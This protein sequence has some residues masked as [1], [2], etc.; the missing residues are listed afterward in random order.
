MLRIFRSITLR[1]DV[2]G[3]SL[4][5]LRWL[6][7]LVSD[8]RSFP[9]H[10]SL[11]AC[12]QAFVLKPQRRFSAA[13]QV[14]VCLVNEDLY[15]VFP[16]CSYFDSLTHLFA[17]IA[18]IFL[19]TRGLIL[20]GLITSLPFL[21]LLSLICL[22]THREILHLTFLSR[23][24]IWVLAPASLQVWHGFAQGSYPA[25]PGTLTSDRD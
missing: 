24:T 1:F 14:R 17:S 23:Y 20:I 12:P 13:E 5:Y 7:R 16:F 9:S 11:F 3:W 6:A 25:P 10:L 2:L 19:S 18:L 15:F 8:Y 4:M 21:H 22:A